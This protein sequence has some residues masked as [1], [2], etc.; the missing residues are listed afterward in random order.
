MKVIQFSFKFSP[1]NHGKTVTNALLHYAFPR[2]HHLLFAYDYRFVFLSSFEH[3]IL[4]FFNFRTLFNST[5]LYFREPYYN[6]QRAISMF[7]DSTDWNKELTR[8]GAV[9]WKLSA[10]NQGFQLSIR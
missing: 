4:S 10:V 8:T 5:V 7:R 3:F 1:P 9:G 2:K 6:C